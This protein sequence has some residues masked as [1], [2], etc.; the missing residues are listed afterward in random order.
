[1]K[2]RSALGRRLWVTAVAVIA[3]GC[4]S[5]TDHLGYDRHQASAGAAGRRS[6]TGGDAGQFA[7]A[8][9]A[10]VAGQTT[11]A[12]QSP[13]STVSTVPALPARVTT[14]LLPR[15]PWC[16][17][18]YLSGY[19]QGL[20]WTSSKSATQLSNAF[21]QL[22]HG[23]PETE[24]IYTDLGNGKAVIRDI[25][26]DNQA[27][28]EGIGVGMLVAVMLNKREEF[29]KLWRYARDELQ[30]KSGPLAGYF[31]SYCDAHAAGSSDDPD[32]LACIDP[33]GFQQFVMALLLARQR[34][35]HSDASPNYEADVLRLFDVMRNKEVDQRIAHLGLSAGGAG[36]TTNKVGPLTTASGGANGSSTSSGVI[37]SSAGSPAVPG[38]EDIVTN[39]FDDT[40]KL[41]YLDP[42]SKARSMTGT[43]LEMPGYYSVWAQLTNDTYYVE[44]AQTARRFL[45]AVAHPKTGFVPVR[46]TFKPDPDSG[47]WG[48]FAPEAYRALL[49]LVIDRL[50]GTDDE[51]QSDQIDRML[52]TFIEKA[53]TGT[54]YGSAY[55]L[56]GE[57]EFI[58][59][60]RVEL[61][62]VNG[63]IA[64]LSNNLAP[65]KKLG[66]IQAASAVAIPTGSTRYYP[67]I[68]YLL[69]NLILAGE[70][71]LCW[72]AQ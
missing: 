54:A 30:I 37:S 23:D 10:H 62:L 6:S 43:A 57:V 41:V 63:V 50:W 49:N 31:S 33:Y 46:A 42:T 60:H 45:T 55:S 70:F 27:R 21:E 39:L 13:S 51:W 9:Q 56:N 11:A 1:M 15:M 29:D 65:D 25:L 59:D 20:G 16:P 71:R 14:V 32:T 67:G 72:G 34:F 69:S 24:A 61:V 52:A 64:M 12:G 66:F 22:F 38:G 2:P 4:T 26:H 40:T 18:S 58:S 36:T 8:G 7:A 48:I 53:S 5:S 68:L 3:G 35:P 19:R 17:T 47:E 44:A 28:T